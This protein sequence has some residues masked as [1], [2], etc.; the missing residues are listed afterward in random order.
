M[1]NKLHPKVHGMGRTS[2]ALSSSTINSSSVNQ[3]LLHIQ[4]VR[5]RVFIE[6]V[7]DGATGPVAL[8]RVAALAG[9]GVSEDFPVDEN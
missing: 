6:H 7:R 4:F 2:K 8:V 9:D 3:C 5:L 1:N